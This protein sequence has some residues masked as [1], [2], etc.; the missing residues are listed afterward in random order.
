MK[1]RK[2]IF[3]IVYLAYTSIYIARINLSMAGPDLLGTGVLDEVQLGLLGSVFSTLY[4]CGR[5]INGGISDKRPPWQ[6]LT[7]G[8]LIAGISNIAISFLP[9]FIAIFVFWTANAY[10]QSML[11]SSVLCVVSSLYD[12]QTAKR[13]TTVM[14]TSVA[15]GNIAAIIICS[16]LITTF[17]VKFAFIVPGAITV[18]LGALVFLATKGISPKE[19]V[20]KKHKS[21]WQLLKDPHIAIMIFPALFHGVMKENISLWMTVFIVDIYNVDLSKSAYYILMIPAIGLIGRTIYTF[22]YKLCNE[23]ENTVS[24]IG[25]IICILCSVLLSIGKTYMIVSVLALSLIYAAVSMINTSMLS[26]LPLHYIKSQNVASVS[27]IMDF[28]TYLGGGI[29][30]FAYGVLIKSLGYTPMFISWV[31]ISGLSV[32]LIIKS[33]HSKLK[34]QTQI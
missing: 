27:G 24:L 31:I 22:I 9:P 29:G 23:K 17:S 25:F 6:M 20:A 1:N 11:W 10:A 19:A 15:V 34:N 32:I 7:T 3:L 26:I 4:A 13:K 8:L 21:M 33:N 14:V 16:F 28:A 12:K 2:L 18:I 30:S 5:L